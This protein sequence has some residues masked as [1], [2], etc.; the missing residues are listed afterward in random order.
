MF[1]VS[2]LLISKTNDDFSYYHLPFTKYLTEH[3]IIFGMGHLNH[4]YNLLSSLFFLN[5]IFY[6]PKIEFYSFHFTII[7]FLI[8]FNFF[9]LNEIFNS[10]N[11]EIINFLYLLSFTYFNLSFN[12][13]AEYGTDK[14]G[15]LLIVIL[16]IKLLQIVSFEKKENQVKQILFLIPLLAYSITLKTYFLPYILLAFVI[17]I[18]KTKPEYVLK[19]I[20]VSKSFLL[21]IFSI[22]I[23]FLHHFISTGCLISPLPTTCLGEYFNLSWARKTSDMTDLS[24]WLEQWAK[25][26]AG[27]NFRVSNVLEYISYF[28]WVHNW[29]NKYFINK[30]LEQLLLLFSSIIVIFLLSKSFKFKKEINNINKNIFYYYSLIIIIFL[31]WFFNHPTLRYGGYAVVFLILSVPISLLFFKYKNNNFFEKRIKFLVLFVIIVFNIKN[32]TRIEN[33]LKRGDHYKFTNFPFYA[34]KEKNFKKYETESGLIIYSAHHCWGVP[35]PCGNIN[36][37]IYVNKKN[38]YY[39]INKR[40]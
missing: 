8:F 39:F 36:E 19:N 2:A 9:V 6:L 16:V 11:N 37:K 1:T 22:I 31:I 32:I 3:K 40:K 29:I 35:T 24:I 28:N 4:G 10:K 17:F 5:S 14:P 26:G 33:E 30:F 7:F 12:R 15:Q 34:I 18:L 23:Y 25:A 21:F 13:L 27:P 20:F 38:N